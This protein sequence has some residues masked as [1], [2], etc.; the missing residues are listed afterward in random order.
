MALL[1]DHL[2]L[3]GALDEQARSIGHFTVS[4]PQPMPPL[5]AAIEVAAYRIVMEAMTNSVRHAKA[6]TGEVEMT[7]DA[8]LHVVVTD[9]GVGLPDGYRAGVGIASMRERAG[10][11]GGTCVVEA[12]HGGGTVVRAWLPA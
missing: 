6:N 8:G 7:Y 4:G 5:S 10:A 9:D 11:L 1:L 2:G 12:G 3:V